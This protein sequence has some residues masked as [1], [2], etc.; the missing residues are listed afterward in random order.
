MNWIK[1]VQDG[2]QNISD[3][4]KLEKLDCVV[5]IAHQESAECKEK[6]T[7]T[8]FAVMGSEI[9]IILNASSFFKENP[10]MVKVFERAIALSKIDTTATYK[11]IRGWLQ[12]KKLAK[13]LQK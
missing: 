6:D 7:N 13:I 9:G 12:K 2:V 10:D 5:V 11:G 1:Q 3:N 4:N 8:S